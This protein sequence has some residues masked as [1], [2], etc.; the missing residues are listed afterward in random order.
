MEFNAMI[1]KLL[2][3]DSESRRRH[4]SRYRIYAGSYGSH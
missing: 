2:K 1:N 3:K 4:L